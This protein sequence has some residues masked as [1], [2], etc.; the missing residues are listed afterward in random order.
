MKRA[1]SGL[2]AGILMLSIALFWIP[3]SAAAQEQ[4]TRTI[5]IVFDNSGSMYVSGEKAWCRATY[6]MEVFG[7][8][9]NS[10]DTLYIY[11]MNPFQVNGKEYTMTSPLKISDPVDSKQIRDI[12]TENASGTPIESIDAAAKGLLSASGDQKYLIV[13]T[14]GNSFYRDDVELSNADTRTALTNCLAQYAGKGMDVLYLGIG[15]NVA[16]PSNPESEH[17][18]KAQASDSRD[19][20]SSLTTMCNLIFG[21]DTLPKN[22]I[23]GNEIDFDISLKKLIV[24]VQGANVSGV[25]VTGPDGAAGT[26]AGTSQVQY[27]SKG[28][29][30]YTSTPDTSLQGMMVTYTDCAPGTYTINYSGTASNVEVYYEPDADLAVQF[31]DPSGHNAD[32]DALY[33]GD[34]TVSFGMMDAKTGELID[35]DLLGSVSYT[36]SYFVNGEEFPV[37][38]S[39][40]SG[41]ETVA[42]GVGDTF[43]ATLTATYLSGYTV[44]KQAEDFGWPSGGLTVVARPAG[45]LVLEVSGGGGVYE[46]ATLEEAEPAIAK[47]YYQGQ[48]LTGTEL[49]SVEI[50][51]DPERSGAYLWKEAEGDHYNIIFT[52]PDG[53]HPENTPVGT[54]SFPMTAYYTPTGSEEAISQPVDFSYTIEDNAKALDIQLEV[55]QSYYQ[56]SK[57]DEGEPLRA[58]LT[59]NGSPLSPEEFEEITFTAD[60]GDVPCTVEACPGESAYLIR[61]GPGDG[62]EEGTYT[63]HCTASVTDEIGRE[64]A[65]EDSADI[66][67]GLL[68]LWLKWVIGIA[69]LLL[70]LLIV[71]LILHIKA[72]PKRLQAR[73]S[74][75]SMSFD[76]EDVTKNAG[77]S[78]DIRKN[79]LNVE[80]K[81]A[82]K[83]TGLQMDVR[84]AA[85]SYVKTPLK[86][87]K[88]DVL[89]GS[90]KKVGNA[91]IQEATIGVVKYV[92][93]PANNRLERVPPSDKPF[94]VKNGTRI[95][96]SGIM[97]EAGVEK[98]FTVAT[99]LSVKKK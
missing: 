66:T 99:K 62:L 50:S 49:E 84:P 74:D 51:W 10:G 27:S 1:I 53:D 91:S 33:D 92:L 41:Q 55:P 86:K 65:A 8:M 44:T 15:S 31:T 76:G 98:A 61:L 38:C 5:A 34:Y 52:H 21:R 30:N 95:S 72:L 68:P 17:F 28:S 97:N 45:E 85:D 57:L 78:A 47:V 43:S 89:S 59:L 64:T 96:Y 67:L 9:L 29:G 48:Q 24:F 63:I 20:L 12:Y 16:M 71:L 42:L 90:V 3:N 94:P 32:P 88:A 75:S 36:G 83:K 25:S 22:H 7:S 2:L 13:L 19:V 60:G 14:D 79:R 69:L 54:F 40:M 87:R 70:L 73:K 35:S 37:E 58:A 56:I 46:L 82:G 6:A 26:E 23:N 93:N 81:F 4:K 18:T 11:P 39:G 80:S 77:F